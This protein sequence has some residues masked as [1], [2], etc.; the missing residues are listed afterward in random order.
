[1]LGFY[2]AVVWIWLWQMAL[3]ARLLREWTGERT[4][5]LTG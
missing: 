1:M 5:H 4:P 3:M 2:A